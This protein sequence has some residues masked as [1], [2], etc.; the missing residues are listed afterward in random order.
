MK[1][2]SFKTIYIALGVALV[3]VAALT[4]I[5]FVPQ[6]LCVRWCSINVDGTFKYVLMTWV[7]GAFILVAIIHLITKIISRAKK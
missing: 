1:I 2:I 3:L 5:V 6:A 4:E 7:L